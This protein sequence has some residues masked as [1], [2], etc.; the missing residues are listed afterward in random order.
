MSASI[1]NAIGLL[2]IAL[3]STPVF[4]ESVITTVAGN[5]VQGFSG[6]NGPAMAAQ[7]FRP[8]GME[9][10]AAGNLYVADTHN[11]R[12]RKIRTDGRIISIA[13]TW[14]QGFSGD[15]GPATLA[16]LAYPSGLALDAEGNLYIADRGN[17]RIRKVTPAGVITTVVGTGTQG[18]SGDGGLATAAELNTPFGVKIDVQ[19]NLYIAD[20][21]N[22]RIR[23]V[24][25]AGFI[26]TVAGGAAGGFGGDGGA[27]TSALLNGP[28]GVEID[29][30]GNLYI[31]DTYNNR[32]RKVSPEGIITT[33]AG[34][35]TPGFSGD[36]GP[37]TSAA[38]NNPCSVGIDVSGNI[39]FADTF[40][41][42][43]R[44]V[45]PEGVITTIA[46]GFESGYG[47]DG[48]PATSAMLSGPV[49]IASNLH[50]SLY[51]ADTGNHRIRK[52]AGAIGTSTFFP[53]IAVGG[54]YKMVI[55]F[56][57]NGSDMLSGTLSLKDQQGN[58]LVI[59]AALHHPGSEEVEL[60]GSDFP[61]LLP[62][63]SVGFLTADTL[64]PEHAI[65][66]GW[67]RI[68]SSGG[69]LYGVAM[70][71][72]VVEEV[73]TSAVGVLPSTLMQ[74]ATV[75]VDDD[76]SQRLLTAY[77]LAN[78]TDQ[79]LVIKI[80]LVD[81]EGNLVDD[82]ISIS[83]L[84]GQHYARY[85]HEDLND[86]GLRFKGSIVIRAQAGGGFTAVAFVQNQDQFTAI[87]VNP[88][89]ASHLPD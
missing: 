67:A 5:G 13:G 72:L 7:L 32:I 43:I 73:V 53:Q 77:A 14:V 80:G 66:A 3:T 35:E 24:T 30:E 6:D 52:V 46:G 45:T 56:G 84:P 25:R 15:G 16:A 76:Y 37:A 75:P 31:A 28:F 65:H 79:N 78:P 57:N 34:V 82:S 23:K 22:N 38:L 8:L 48:G 70:Y 36:G 74:Y 83:L 42:R 58:P 40:N 1:R 63:G 39:L 68:A 20:T 41:S 11:H 86:P 59:R 89:K 9:I 81:E 51:I 71:Q 27:A 4:A 54:G 64:D 62:P 88:G 55:T 21:F 18:F 12:I 2:C 10:D 26:S 47:G 19:G 87:P 61:I 85:L 17:N 33:L 60:T 50:G 49:G 69:S 44:M 29:P